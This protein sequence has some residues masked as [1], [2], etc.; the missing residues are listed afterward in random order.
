[1]HLSK[2]SVPANTVDTEQS[3]TYVKKLEENIQTGVLSDGF[4][5]DKASRLAISVVSN[6]NI[7]KRIFNMQFNNAVEQ[8]LKEISPIASERPV[9]QYQYEVK[10][11][12]EVYFY[13]VFAGLS[14]PSSIKELVAENK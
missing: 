10:N 14:L 9:A 7:A 2:F 5:L 11:K 4:R 3:L 13:A 8:K 12:S 1:L 6:E